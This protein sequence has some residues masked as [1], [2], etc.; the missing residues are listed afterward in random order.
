MRLDVLERQACRLDE[1]AQRADLVEHVVPGLLSG[2]LHDPAAEAE[3][4]GIARVRPDGH[5]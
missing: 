5:P 1:G 4:I 2:D 3:E